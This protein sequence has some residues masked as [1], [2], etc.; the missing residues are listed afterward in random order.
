MLRS[1]ASLCFLEIT[2]TA[3]DRSI[4]GRL[5]RFDVDAGSLEFLS[6]QGDVRTPR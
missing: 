3:A 1:K 4:S 5:A 2:T 6:L